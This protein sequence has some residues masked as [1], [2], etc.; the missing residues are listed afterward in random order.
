MKMQYCS[1]LHLESPANKKY[2]E[3]HLPE[4]VSEVFNIPQFKTAATTIC[5]NQL[6]Y[7]HHSQQYK[8]NKSAVP[9][10]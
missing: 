9:E 8:F 7:V 10:V 1:D 5:T 4:P 2:L 3:Q 6:G